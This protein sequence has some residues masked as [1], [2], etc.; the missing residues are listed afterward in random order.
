MTLM[1]A[2]LVALPL[3]HQNLM[4]YKTG[5]GLSVLRNAASHA[6]L[7]LWPGMPYSALSSCRS[8]LAWLTW[9]A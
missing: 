3:H 8:V 6:L 1:S 7:E 4:W 5:A 2:T 9:L